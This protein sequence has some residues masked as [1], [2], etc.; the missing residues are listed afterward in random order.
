MPAIVDLLNANW[1]NLDLRAESIPHLLHWDLAY[2]WVLERNPAHRPSNWHDRIEAWRRLVYA[3][4]LGEFELVQLEVIEPLSGVL[5]NAGIR[6]VKLARYNGQPVG[7]LS[8]TV[9]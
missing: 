5:L 4:L 8:P 2:L 6:E 9:L 3:F 1:E 7:V